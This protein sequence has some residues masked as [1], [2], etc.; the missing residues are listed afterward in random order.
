M[1]P[2]A[3][4]LAGRLLIAGGSVLY[5]LLTAS[6]IPVSDGVAQDLFNVTI[7]AFLAG[8]IVYFAG[9]Y[10]VSKDWAKT[11]L[12]TIGFGALWAIIVVVGSVVMAFSAM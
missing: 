4:K 8:V 9:G 12:A 2:R 5:L 3:L 6:V 7:V 11:S 10:L 1:N